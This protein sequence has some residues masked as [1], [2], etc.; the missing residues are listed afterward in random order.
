M[1]EVI[2][3]D[4]DITRDYV[5]RI[6]RL[7]GLADGSI[8]DPHLRKL[9]HVAWWMVVILAAG[10]I[11]VNW[12]RRTYVEFHSSGSSDCSGRTVSLH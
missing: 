9:D 6:E 8:K 5:D 4:Y 1:K 12:E 10:Y 11:L 3:I 7:N 2:R